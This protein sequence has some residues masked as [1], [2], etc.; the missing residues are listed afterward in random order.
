MPSALELP[1]T[2]RERD[3]QATSYLTSHIPKGEQELMN[4]AW[5]GDEELREALT[6]E[7]V[8]L[9]SLLCI[10]CC[11]KSVKGS[12]NIG[13]EG[14]LRDPVASKCCDSS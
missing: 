12:E 9:S 14:G 11:I 10:G 13:I 4:S 1:Q 5:Q 3:E 2:T 7:I 6:T 8:I